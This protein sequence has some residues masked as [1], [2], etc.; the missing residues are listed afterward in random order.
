MTWESYRARLLASNEPMRDPERIMRISAR[1]LLIQ[2]EKA[3]RQAVEDF[4]EDGRRC[5]GSSDVPDFLA[6]LFGG[7]GKG[8]R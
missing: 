2:L 1:S 8:E 4:V 7:F 6:E 3:Y 5:G